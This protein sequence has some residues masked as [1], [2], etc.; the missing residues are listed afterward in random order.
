MPFQIGLTSIALDTRS[1]DE[2]RRLRI[3]RPVG[4]KTTGDEMFAVGGD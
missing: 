3:E 4:N 1:K 2:I